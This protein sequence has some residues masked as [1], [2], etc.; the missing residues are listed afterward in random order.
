MIK[1]AS[2]NSYPLN[3]FEAVSGFIM[4]QDRF[5]RT[6]AVIWNNFDGMKTSVLKGGAQVL[7]SWAVSSDSV[8][9]TMPSIL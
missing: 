6:I 7:S 9:V 1:K 2:L 5:L 3:I 4:K 8:K